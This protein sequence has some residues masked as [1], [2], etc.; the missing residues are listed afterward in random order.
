MSS[1]LPEGILLV[2]K[3][4]SK[5]SFH[6]VAILR[7][8][9]GQPKVGHAGT[10]DPF[11]TGLLVLLF[12]R[13]WTRTAGFF[14]NHD[15]EYIATIRLGVETDTYDRDGQIVST[16]EEIPSEDRVKKVLEE[17]QGEYLQTPPMYSARKYGGKRLYDLAR[18]GIT[19]QRE[20][21]KTQIATT[22]LSYCYPQLTV[23]VQCSKGTYVRSLAHDI[24]DRLGCGAHVVELRRIRSGPFSLDGAVTLAEIDQMSCSEVQQRFLFPDCL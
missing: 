7:K 14:L 4:S 21:T 10:L 24:G 18:K 16:S 17:F 2:D 9:L 3:P 22:V 1:S 23:Y 19:V 8:K 6:I 12:G 20:P 15:K 5:S 13:R 11:A